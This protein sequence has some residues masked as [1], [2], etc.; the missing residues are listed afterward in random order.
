MKKGLY[1]S[2]ILLSVISLLITIGSI[3]LADYD[4][5]GPIIVSMGDSYS[6]GEGIEEFYGQELPLAEKV[7]NQDWLA[8]R[9]KESWPGRL[10]FP[11]LSGPLKDY[12]GEYVH[13]VL[14]KGNWYFVAASSAVTGDIR[15]SQEKTYSRFFNNSFTVVKTL[16]TN[17]EYL[18]P[19]IEV[20]EELRKQGKQVDY[21]TITIGGNDMGFANVLEK[22]AMNKDNLDLKKTIEERWQLFYNS[23]RQDIKNIY[24]RIYEE[25]DKKA[26]IIVAGYPRLIDPKGTDDLG[27][28]FSSE[29]AVYINEQV[30]LFNREIEKIVEECRNECGMKIFFVSVEEAFGDHGAYSEGNLINPVV[31]PAQSEDLDEIAV[32]SAY[33][34]HPNTS[35]AQV[36]ANCVQEFIDGYTAQTAGPG[37]VIFFGCYEQDNDVSN[38]LEPIE[39]IVLDK[40]DDGSLVLMSRY[41]LDAKPFNR[42][43]VDITWANS[44]LRKW[45]NED[46]VNAAFTNLE[47]ERLVPTVL[48]NDDNLVYG[49]DGGIMTQDRVWLLSID[50]V[51]GYYRND[52]IYDC[53]S[54]NISRLCTPTP[55]A[56]A[57]GII[58]DRE[59]KINGKGTCEWLLRSPGYDPGCAT[60]VDCNGDVPPGGIYILADFG[61]IRPVIMIEGENTSQVTVADPENLFH[62]GDILYGS[63]MY[64]TVHSEPGFN[65]DTM[66]GEL[67]AKEK[68]H[69]REIRWLESDYSEDSEPWL[70]VENQRILG[71]VY[72]YDL[73][74]DPGNVHVYD[75]DALLTVATLPSEYKA[76]DTLYA[77]YSLLSV[78]SMPGY[79][80]DSV[81]Q[82]EEKEAVTVVHVEWL[83]EES[84]DEKVPWLLV[85]TQ[86]AQGWVC[87]WDLVWDPDDTGDYFM[88]YDG[89]GKQYLS[90]FVGEWEM[91]DEEYS[92][93]RITPTGDGGYVLEVFL[94]RI[95]SFEA[96]WTG[97]E[98]YAE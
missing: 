56:V 81:D 21:V 52:R 55:Y 46:F 11:G 3:A 16:K 45:L 22:A 14:T 43:Y 85:E 92:S 79:Q 20:L 96:Y 26:T 86:R 65:I 10:R 53:F 7:L 80:G 93:A 23:I 66:V 35:G 69:V 34:I 74:E 98:E 33:S 60:Y 95:T 38:G 57:H 59:H 89:I 8:H 70:L 54:N 32:V 19:Q 88:Y 82:L 64:V 77:A 72:G 97:G 39:W 17:K 29:D 18:T 15:G 87:G 78:D 83:V 62:V 91:M 71:W 28:L 76:G 24:Y 49:T 4:P 36:Y 30:T 2:F 44:T 12:R 9:S 48:I 51:T 47:Q 58:P 25:T 27:V 73:M 50:E 63:Y 94:Y 37:D 90:D 68:V 13:G 84:T 75:D 67:N 42:A 41:A 1:I 31:F 6:A 61:G 5:D 40:R